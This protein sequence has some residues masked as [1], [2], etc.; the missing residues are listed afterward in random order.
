MPIRSITTPIVVISADAARGRNDIRSSSLDVLDWLNKPID[1]GQLV[2]VLKRP[3]ARNGGKRPSILHIDDDASVREIV[4]EAIGEGCKV[5]SVATIED[6]RQALADNDFDL[7]VLDLLLSQSSGLDLLPE[8]RGRDGNAI[9]VILY[10]ARAANGV[11]A[12]HVQAA[13]HKS[14]RS[15]DHLIVT[16]RKY[17]AGGNRRSAFQPKEVA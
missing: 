14:H 10:S 13:L 8:L 3:L 7:A 4:A 2:E 12:A 1:T 15:I 17:T 11:N 6:A 5:T 9:P 16:L